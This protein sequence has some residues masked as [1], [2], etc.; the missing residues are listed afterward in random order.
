[1]EDYFLLPNVYVCRWASFLVG[2]TAKD[3]DHLTL[4]VANPDDLWLH[5]RGTPGSHVVVRLEKGATVPPET[6]KDAATL[7]LWFSDLRKSGKGEVIYTLRKFVRKGKGFKPG[8]VTVEREKS[9]WIEVKEDRLNRLK[10][11]TK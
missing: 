5:A 3:N 10:G 1:M 9:L 4:K 7:T 6:L 11:G 2:K 8:S